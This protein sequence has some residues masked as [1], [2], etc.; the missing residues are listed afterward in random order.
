MRLISLSRSACR[1]RTLVLSR[2]SRVFLPILE[3]ILPTAPLHAV[4][5]CLR[6]WAL[7]EK[8]RSIRI[9]LTAVMTVSTTASVSR[10]RLGLISLP[11]SWQASVTVTAVLF[12]MVARRL[13][14]HS[15][16]TPLTGCLPDCH[17]CYQWIPMLH[18]PIL[19]SDTGKANLRP[20]GL[21]S[22]ALS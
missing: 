19:A 16:V 6:V 14:Y 11:Q 21:T 3:L 2:R 17:D 18:I 10:R 20:Q 15:P 5:L 8:S 4:T 9:S 12:V 22:L 13:Y 1:V 7:Y